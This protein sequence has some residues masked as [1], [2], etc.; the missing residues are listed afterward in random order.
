M[1]MRNV[2]ELYVQLTCIPHW[3]LY[4]SRAEQL[5][6]VGIH[7]MHYRLYFTTLGTWP[8]NPG[9]INISEEINLGKETGLNFQTYIITRLKDIPVKNFFTGIFMQ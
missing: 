4:K 3:V 8:L 9:Q 2:N 7:Y 5:F 6:H 1:H